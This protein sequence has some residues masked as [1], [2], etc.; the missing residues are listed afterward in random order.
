MSDDQTQQGED[1]TDEVIDIASMT[2]EQLREH[3][4]ALTEHIDQLSQ[5]PL[6]P[7]L[8]HEINELR[9]ERNAAAE[10]VNS[11]VTFTPV[12]DAPLAP[13]APTAEETEAPEA[14]ATEDTTTTTNKETAVSDESTP[15]ADE[16]IAAAEAVI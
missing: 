12:D 1:T 7:A 15:A 9:L 2:Q 14:A 10:A 4:A 6:T 13:V 11:L 3:Y 8:A 16:A 5:G